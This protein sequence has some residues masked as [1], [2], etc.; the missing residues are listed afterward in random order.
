MKIQ[1]SEAE[2][3]EKVYAESENSF[4]RSAISKRNITEIFS[5]EILNVKAPEF[6]PYKSISYRNL[7]ERYELLIKAEN[8]L[9]DNKQQEITSTR[10]KKTIFLR[11]EIILK[12]IQKKK[13]NSTNSDQ[14]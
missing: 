9:D 12:K 5:E 7:K 13:E 6:V 8:N 3:I 11:Q 10:E 2:A 4:I 14:K 1:L